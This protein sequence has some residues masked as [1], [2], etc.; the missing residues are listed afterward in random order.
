VSTSPPTIARS[1]HFFR[2][3]VGRDSA[4]RAIPLDAA[5]ALGEISELT[6][7]SGD[8][9]LDCGDGTHLACWVDRANLPA[10]AR[11]ANVRRIG[12]PQIEEGGELGTLPL[13][14][15]QGVSDAIHVAFYDAGIVG[16]D[17][18]FYGP[19]AGSRVP[20]YLQ[21]KTSVGDLS[22]G[23]LVHPAISDQLDRL[24][25]LRLFSLRIRRSDVESLAAADESLRDAFE[26]AVGLGDAAEIEVI[27][28]VA[29]H[30][31]GSLSRVYTD[32]A[33]KLVQLPGITHIAKTFRVVGVDHDTHRATE[34]NLLKDALVSR[35]QVV[36]LSP[37][38]RAVRSDSAYEAID[39]AFTQLESLLRR[40]ASIQG[41]PPF[42][43]DS[44]SA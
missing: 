19:R 34:V 6:W 16:C 1:I 10:R 15:R 18:N 24:D 43:L 39:T 4:G 44:A 8:R 13:T 35:Q 11:F 25:G 30:S 36:R 17:F 29:A 14:D 7:Q 32:L 42:D 41:S 12:L 9:Y 5:A 20:W 27:A 31:R 28:R 2:T 33:R 40:A 23:R 21:R 37:E 22:F 3:S 38:D 26:A